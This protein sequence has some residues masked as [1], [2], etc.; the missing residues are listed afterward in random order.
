MFI[1][2]S[3]TTCAFP[4]YGEP[5]AEEGALAI[6]GPEAA[7]PVG[8]CSAEYD[9][10]TDGGVVGIDGKVEAWWKS[11]SAKTGAS[12]YDCGTRE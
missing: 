10:G 7:E 2:L 6:E 3:R 11:D 12:K 8:M 5:S 4:E 9:A 1:Q